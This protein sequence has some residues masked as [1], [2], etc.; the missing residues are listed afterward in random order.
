MWREILECRK[1]AVF[2]RR[3]KFVLS[4]SSETER[5]WRITDR[6]PTKSQVW[7]TPE[8]LWG[9]ESLKNSCGVWISCWT[10]GV[11]P[12]HQIPFTDTAPWLNGLALTKTLS[13]FQSWSTRLLG[14]KKCKRLHHNTHSTSKTGA[15]VKIA[16]EYTSWHLPSTL[17][18]TRLLGVLALDLL[19]SF[20]LL[21][22]ASAAATNAWAWE[23]TL[24]PTF[25]E[26]CFGSWASPA[27]LELRTTN[28]WQKWSEKCTSRISKLCCIHIKLSNFLKRENSWKRFQVPF[29]FRYRISP[30]FSTS[31]M[32][33]FCWKQWKMVVA[34]ENFPVIIECANVDRGTRTR[35]LT[36]KTASAP[37]TVGFRYS[38]WF[39]VLGTARGRNWARS[40]WRQFQTYASCRSSRLRV[41]S[42]PTT[43]A[44]SEICVLVL[45]PVP[46]QKQAHHRFESARD[47]PT[48]S[49]TWLSGEMPRN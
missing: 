24:R 18:D 3:R 28:C 5:I 36:R 40:R 1:W 26:R 23:L 35:K 8:V 43:H 49:A 42:G 7:W 11:S 16:P 31:L 19:W 21:Q 15:Q 20:G 4:W 46:S 34:E 38:A 27:V 14:Q 45:T 39:K 47:H 9:T 29:S 48:F 22:S 44:R 30:L 2:L 37:Q 17:L 25:V 32:D 6:C 33:H 12:P 41:Q 10:I 13:M